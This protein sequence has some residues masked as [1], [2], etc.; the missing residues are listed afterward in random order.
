MLAI[1]YATVIG[2][3]RLHVMAGKLAPTGDRERQLAVFTHNL[4]LASDAVAAKNIELMIEPIN[5]RVDIPDYLIECSSEGMSVIERVARPNVRLQ[6]DVYHM[7]IVEGDLARTIH[8]LLPHI[9]HIQIADNPGRNEPGTGE[10]NFD[11][12][13]QH[14]DAMGYRGWIGCE[15][16]PRTRTLDGL[17][18]ASRYL[19]HARESR[20]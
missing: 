9:G 20:P 15:Y 16:R 8:R 12:L 4:L 14:I 19:N 18:W 2:C 1:E 7:Q 13:L 17:R 11:W 5:R 6:Y 3:S 10:I